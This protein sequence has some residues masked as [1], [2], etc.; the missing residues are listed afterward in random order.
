MCYC[1]FTC[2]AATAT[3]TWIVYCSPHKLMDNK[4][5]GSKTQKWKNSI[6]QNFCIVSFALVLFLRFSY[7]LVKKVNQQT[8]RQSESENKINKRKKREPLVRSFVGCI[9]LTVFHGEYRV[10][11]KLEIAEREKSE[12]HL[13]R[14]FFMFVLF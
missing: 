11:P 10:T 14:V 5:K 2:C 4:M 6:L 1:V 13:S 7:F 8:E 9:F 12:S 3:A